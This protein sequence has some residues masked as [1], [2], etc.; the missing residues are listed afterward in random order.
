M[1][2]GGRIRGKKLPARAEEAH[3]AALVPASQKPAMSEEKKEEKEDFLH[4]WSRRKHEDK[5]VPAAQ[6]EKPAPALPPVDKLTPESDFTGFMHPKVEDA[7]RRVA[8]K[9]L[10]SDPHFNVAD[11]F[12]AYSGDWTGGEPIPEEMLAALNQAKR[13]LF[14][15]KKEEEAKQQVA[16]EE[17]PKADE[18]GRKDA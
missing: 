14:D 16:S 12:E 8:L 4:R 1:R 9:K 10:F 2:L 15:E 5:K 7:L 13:L 18:P 6:D 17:K 11:P 3:Q